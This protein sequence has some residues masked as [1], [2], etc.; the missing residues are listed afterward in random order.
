MAKQLS[1]GVKG[2]LK[3]HKIDVVMG[4]ATIPAKGKVSVKTDKGTEELTGKNIIV[5]TGARAR[6]L[7]GLE[8]DGDLVWT[9]KH[10][11]DPKRM[12]KASGHRF[13]RNR[14]R[15]QLLQHLGVGHDRG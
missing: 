14:H 10:A 13:R 12:Q 9:Y 2:L 5:A 6:E 15:V 11:L 8:A 7:P 3:K 4:A 1:A